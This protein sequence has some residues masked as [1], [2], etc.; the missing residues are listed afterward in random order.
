VSA[1]RAIPKRWLLVRSPVPE[2]GAFSLAFLN[3]D[4]LAVGEAVAG[5][6]LNA[7]RFAYDRWSSWASG[8]PRLLGASAAIDCLLAQSVPC[9]SHILFI[10]LVRKA[11]IEDHA[12]AAPLI[13][14]NRRYRRLAIND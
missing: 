11:I 14:S 4:Q 3:E 6:W 5:R 7:D 8:Q 2:A 1:A 12:K 13:W 9:A 10:G